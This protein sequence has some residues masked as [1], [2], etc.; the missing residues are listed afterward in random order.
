MFIFDL[1]SFTDSILIIIKI[2][3]ETALFNTGAVSPPSKI[4]QEGPLEGE[5]VIFVCRKDTSAKVND[6][7]RCY[8]NFKNCML[9]VTFQS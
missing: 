6:A 4:K 7:F 2:L 8:N 9:R 1:H 3:S 5:V